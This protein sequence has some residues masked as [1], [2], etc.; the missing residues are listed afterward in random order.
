MLHYLLFRV[1]SQVKNVLHL[2]QELR[3]MDLSRGRKASSCYAGTSLKDTVAMWG[4]VNCHYSLPHATTAVLVI[5]SRGPNRE[6]FG[7]TCT[8][9]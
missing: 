5:N 7:A 9:Q 3:E 1:N 8:I 2:L 6:T 4:A